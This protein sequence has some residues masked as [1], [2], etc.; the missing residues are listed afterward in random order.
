MAENPMSAG[1]TKHTDVRYHF[2]RELVEKKVL[3][4]VYRKTEEQPADVLTKPLARESSERHGRF[5]MNLP[6]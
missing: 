6:M 1:R 2:I 5:L 4:M 3:R